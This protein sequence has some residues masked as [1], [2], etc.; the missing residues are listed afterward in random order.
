MLHLLDEV[1]S[2]NDIKF[3]SRAQFAV[4]KAEQISMEFSRAK[5]E[6][7]DQCDLCN[8]PPTKG[9]LRNPGENR[10]CDCSA[11]TSLFMILP[12]ARHGLC[13]RSGNLSVDTFIKIEME[14]K[15][16]ERKTAKYCRKIQEVEMFNYFK[17]NVISG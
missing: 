5:I 4:I 11:L 9:N 1:K 17:T 6:T 16:F 2:A 15:H 13:W 7:F 3:Q 12:V 8:L 14:G 10:E